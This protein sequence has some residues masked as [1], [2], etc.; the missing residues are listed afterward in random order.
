MQ[1]GGNAA[2]YGAVQQPSQ[3]EEAVSQQTPWDQQTN[4]HRGKVAI[5]ALVLFALLGAIVNSQYEH[6]H[7]SL[8]EEGSKGLMNFE[9]M[10]DDSPARSSCCARETEPVLGGVD[11]VE[12][13]FIPPGSTPVFGSPDISSVLVTSKGSF[14]FYFSNEMNKMAFEMAPW[15]YAPAMGGFDA[16][17]FSTEE[18]YSQPI[19]KRNIGPDA[20]ITKWAIVNGKLL[21]FSDDDSTGLFQDNVGELIPEGGARWKKLFSQEKDGLFNTRCFMVEGEGV[22][23]TVDL[24]KDNKDSANDGE[25]KEKDGGDGQGGDGKKGG[26]GKNKGNGSKG[27]GGGG[28]GGGDAASLEVSAPSVPESSCPIMISPEAVLTR[29][30]SSMPELEVCDVEEFADA[31]ASCCTKNTYAALGGVDV[32]AYRGLS[33]DELPV[34]GVDTYTV[35]V[36]STEKAYT[37]WF[38]TLDNMELFKANPC[39]YIPAFGGF[40]AFEFG[41]DSQYLSRQAK[42]D[43]GPSA[44][45]S[46]WAIHNDILYLFSSSENKEQFL[47]EATDEK[48]LQGTRAWVNF[49]GDFWNGLFN[50]HCYVGYSVLNPLAESGKGG[51]GGGGRKTYLPATVELEACDVSE[52]NED[53]YINYGRLGCCSDQ[54]LPVLGGIDVVAVRDLDSRTTAVPPFGTADNVAILLS[55]LGE[56]MFFFQSEANRNKF[57]EDPWYYAPAY[58]GFSAFDLT[59]KEE[60]ENMEGD[61]VQ[62]LGPNADLANWVVY[63]DRLYFL[64]D[65]RSK[66][67]FMQM[68]DT[69]I[70]EGNR[71][72][73]GMFDHVYGGAFNTRCMQFTDPVETA[74]GELVPL[75]VGAEIFPT[76][77]IGIGSCRSFED[78][79]SRGKCCTKDRYA[80]FDGVDVVA[81]SYLPDGSEP[82]MGKEEFPAK[83]QT[84]EKAYLFYFSSEENRNA[85]LENPWA[86]A[87]AWGGF[88]A[89]AMSAENEWGR[90]GSKRILGPDPDLSQWAYFEGRLYVFGNADS[91]AAWMTNPYPHLDEAS[92]RWSGWYGDPF[93]GVFNTK[94]YQGYTGPKLTMDDE[95]PIKNVDVPAQVELNAC[96]K[97]VDGSLSTCCSRA[98]YPLLGG[99]DLVSFRVPPA[100]AEEGMAAEPTFGSSEHAAT[101][102]LPNGVVT[103]Y[104][105]SAENQALFEED[106]WL[107]MPAFGGFD[108]FAVPL[109][110]TFESPTAFSELGPAVNFNQWA[111]VEDR[112]Y[113]FRSEMNR[114]WFMDDPQ[115]FVAAGDLRWTTWFGEQ[116][117]IFNTHC[118]TLD[119]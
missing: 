25:K 33:E 2:L 70:E 37:F 59:V 8:M 68:P 89:Y 62:H 41:S 42:R 30:T 24:S 20:D 22:V 100:G 107:Y 80:V 88:D 27:G 18:Q 83:L 110:N 14:T 47:V 101:V 86:Y 23:V 82:V 109:Q 60:F 111:V 26:D 43:L 28:G 74:D 108:A 119:Q 31:R 104:F 61:A 67:Y 72:W 40:D 102:E 34:F 114:R 90:G 105:A 10:C 78:M 79:S 75:A 118:F 113:F 29:A 15:D 13:R 58:G 103:A 94:C 53:D 38:S 39:Q 112:L 7:A 19:A 81:Y 50:T 52:Y 49:Y 5:L 36:V 55:D 51:N 76:G 71:R 87:P 56:Y 4:T 93:D 12:F 106:P 48:V 98:E 1:T 66:F 69:F 85:F 116:N 91:K 65:A 54:D 16:Y 96:S 9:S 32:V 57:L 3:E 6:S 95:V 64:T 35:S 97:S 45:V 46:I 63:G 84:S 11:V 17:A 77:P 44:D 115:D 92:K 21:F 73:K 99:L 117:G